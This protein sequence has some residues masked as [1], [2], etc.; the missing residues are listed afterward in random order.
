M[1]M[2]CSSQQEIKKNSLSFYAGSLNSGDLRIPGLTDAAYVILPAFSHVVFACW[3][4]STDRKR[5][6]PFLLNVKQSLNLG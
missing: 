2:F 1:N 3:I 6:V 5:W 4:K